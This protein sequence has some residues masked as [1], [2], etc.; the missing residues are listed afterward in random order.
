M[1]PMKA[2]KKVIMELERVIEWE[3]CEALACMFEMELPFREERNRVDA[4]SRCSIH[5]AIKL[6]KGH[7]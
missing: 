4:S 7:L 5:A 2:S 1:Q 6:G 3:L